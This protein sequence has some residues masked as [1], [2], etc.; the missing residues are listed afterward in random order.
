MTQLL[1]QDSSPWLFENWLSYDWPIYLAFSL[2]LLTLA[3][4]VAAAAITSWHH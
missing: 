2:G 3:G 1:I 4:I